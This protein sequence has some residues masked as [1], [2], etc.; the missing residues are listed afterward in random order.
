[1]QCMFGN[2][3]CYP[4]DTW[5]GLELHAVSVYIIC[6]TSMNTDYQ[7]LSHVVCRASRLAEITKAKQKIC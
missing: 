7:Y 1:M 3:S 4:I 6:V 2:C 5:Y